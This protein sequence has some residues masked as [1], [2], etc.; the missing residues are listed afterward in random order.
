MTDRER[1]DAKP[2]TKKLASIRTVLVHGE[3]PPAS[4]AARR[5]TAPHE[6]AYLPIRT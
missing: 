1:I 2:P 4:W 3:K 5:Y 6:A